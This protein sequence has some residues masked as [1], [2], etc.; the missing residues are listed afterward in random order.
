MTPNALVTE[1]DRALPGFADYNASSEDLFDRATSCG[2]VAACS[3]FVRERP[4][5][6]ECWP[7]LATIL[8]RVATGSDAIAAEAACAC[9]ENLTDPVDPLKPFLEGEALRFW[10]MWQAAG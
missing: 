8:N 3:H 1:L 9:F 7:R 4:V 2:V 10:S 5:A 6:G